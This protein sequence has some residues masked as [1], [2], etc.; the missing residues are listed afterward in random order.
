MATPDK[1]ARTPG[2]KKRKRKAPPVEN[3]VGKLLNVI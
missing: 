3:P 2:E 1:N